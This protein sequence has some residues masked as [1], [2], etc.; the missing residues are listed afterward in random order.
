MAAGFKTTVG[1]LAAGPPA[2]PSD[3]DVWIAT[4]VDANG[5]RWSFQ[6]NGTSTK[7][8]FIGGPPLFTAAASAVNFGTIA[9][10]IL[11]LTATRAGDYIARGSYRFTLGTT[12][13][14]NVQA[15]VKAGSAGSTN[16]IGSVFA[17]S[18]SGVD[19][20]GVEDKVTA[21]AGQAVILS[22]FASASSSPFDTTID[23]WL[24][25]TPIRVS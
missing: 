19:S 21:T 9:A 11:S 1:T 18:N 16:V 6:Y 8:E 7:W 13:A 5:T 3:G 2:S 14:R 24:A 15:G 25:L 22:A 4:T 10:T 20:V 12:T 17:A 23:G